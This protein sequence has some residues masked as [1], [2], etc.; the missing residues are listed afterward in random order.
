LA[1]QND[2]PTSPIFIPKSYRSLDPDHC[3]PTLLAAGPQNPQF[4]FVFKYK[5]EYHSQIGY[6]HLK[7]RRLNRI[8]LIRS[9]YTSSLQYTFLY[10]ATSKAIF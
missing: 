2:T 10:P 3:F 6:S 1:G 4:R 9:I 5:T 7:F 8:I